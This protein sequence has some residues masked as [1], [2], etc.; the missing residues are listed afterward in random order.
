MRF[1]PISSGI[2]THSLMR[3]VV[4]GSQVSLISPEFAFSA[5]STNALKQWRQTQKLNWAKKKQ[6]LTLGRPPKKKINV[7]RNIALFHMRV[8]S[9]L[10]D[11][12][13]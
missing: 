6:G 2:V 13:L 3:A 5:P 4:E 1:D 9:N 10:A 11:K 8:L 12:Y 7:H